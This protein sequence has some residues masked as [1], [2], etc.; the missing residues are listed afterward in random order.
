MSAAEGKAC[1][2]RTT[3]PRTHRK[4]QA[5]TGAWVTAK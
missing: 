4:S 2:P 3:G 5:D 1:H